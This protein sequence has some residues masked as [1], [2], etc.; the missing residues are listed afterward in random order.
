VVIEQSDVAIDPFIFDSRVPLIRVLEDSSQVIWFSQRTGWGHLYL[1]DLISGEFVT[2]ITSGEWNVSSIHHVDQQNQ[3]VYFTAVGKEVDRDPYYDHLYRVRL[4]GGEIELLTPE[5]ATHHIQFAPDGQ[6]FIDTFSTVTEAPTTVIRRCDGTMI[7]EVARADISRLIDAGWKPPLRFVAPD[8]EGNHV[9][10]GILLLPSW[11]DGAQPL[12][13]LDDIYA[14]PHVNRVPT[15]FADSIRGRNA[16]FF[17]IESYW[18]A[19]AIAELGFAVVMID[20]AGRPGRSQSEHLRSYRNVRDGGLPDHISAIRYLAESRSYLDLDRVG[21][22][23]NSAGGFPTVSALLDHPDF[24]KVGV[25]SG[26]NHDHR[27]DKASWIERY[28]GFPPGPHY[29]EQAN[30]NG[31]ERL[32]GKLLLIHAEMDENVHLASTMLVVNALINANK[33]FDFLV[34]PNRPHYC[35]EDPYYI[36]RKW[37]YFVEHL[38]NVDPPVNYGI[39]AHPG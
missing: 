37:D 14:G 23:G 31:V 18:Q 1:V 29:T 32:R 2:Q 19:T 12:P 39:N 17:R 21:M 5:V 8:R 7:G 25:S 27:L 11:H 3:Y 26:G 24:F 13:V 4:D 33:T 6:H 36:R 16:G 35:T 20:G 30:T 28:M 34:M 10:H 15:P 9:T 38:L 22:Y